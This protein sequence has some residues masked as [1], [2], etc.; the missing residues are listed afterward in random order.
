MKLAGRFMLYLSP[1]TLSLAVDSTLP[2]WASRSSNV[3]AE[4][5]YAPSTFPL[6]IALLRC[7]FLDRDSTAPGERGPLRSH[8]ISRHRFHAA[9]LSEDDEDPRA[10]PLAAAFPP[11]LPPSG[12][13]QGLS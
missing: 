12:L 1:S 13:S 11:G 5:A 4:D 2:V 10:T 7:C 6:M 8:S 9:C 3:I